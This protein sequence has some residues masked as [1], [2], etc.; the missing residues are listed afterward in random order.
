MSHFQF[1]R[2]RRVMTFCLG[3]SSALPLVGSAQ[4]KLPAIFAPQP[5]VTQITRVNSRST[6]NL[7]KL[8]GIRL[9]KTKISQSTS[10]GIA[11]VTDP[12]LF[13]Q[14]VAN[15]TPNGYS[16][17][18]TFDILWGFPTL[19]FDA[20]TDED[21]YNTIG[22]TL[23][24]NAPSTANSAFMS[25]G[26]L[27]GPAMITTIGYGGTIAD[28]R[29]QRAGILRIIIYDGATLTSDTASPLYPNNA[30]IA[31][32]ADGS[33][34]IFDVPF[35]DPGTGSNFGF[36]TSTLDPTTAGVKITDPQGRYGIIFAVTTDTTNAAEPPDLH[37]EGVI[38]SA[39]GS[40]LTFFRR[41]TATG[42]NG[43]GYATINPPGTV[44]PTNPFNHGNIS[45]TTTGRTYLSNP[46]LNYIYNLHG[47]AL[48]GTTRPSRGNLDGNVRLRG[49]DV[50]A[51]VAPEKS[52]HQYRIDLFKSP[53]PTGQTFG[54][55]VASYFVYNQPSYKADG[56]LTKNFRIDGI[57]TGTYDL[58]VTW[59]PQTYTTRTGTTAVTFSESV[60][61]PN[62]YPGSDYVP[63]IV[64]NVVIADA[65][66]VGGFTSGTATSLLPSQ[67]IRL[68]RFGDINKDGAIDFGDLSTMLQGY[69]SFD[70]DALY[71]QYKAADISGGPTADFANAGPPDGAIDFGDLSA[72]LQY[73]N[74]V[75]DE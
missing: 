59:L 73:Y 34:A 2:T 15:S 32:T 19:G 46:P 57:P 13:S 47:L 60:R 63:A 65:G 38:G 17:G 43:V 64:R 37:W 71:A 3:L 27:G 56:S 66:V 16:A 45:T 10:V 25:L 6:V 31:K 29:A 62:Q 51:K 14:S 12:F 67:P 58:Q 54:N 44:V 35:A 5:L 33:D 74:T 21:I 26:R 39:N 30:P 55:F 48:D 4:Q 61:Q 41:T 8:R 75:L 68:E 7:N 69:N 49:I 28:S 42:T 23:K 72:L 50:P 36:Y 52:P 40:N 53:A 9:R 70:G 20:A 11:A 24:S 18:Y 1:A 22:T